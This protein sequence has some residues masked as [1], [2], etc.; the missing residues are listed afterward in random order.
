M[1]SKTT[2]AVLFAAATLL[3][4]TPSAFAQRPT[5]GFDRLFLSFIE[6]AT[7]PESQWWEGQ[8]EFQDGDGFDATIARGI[9]AIEWRDR[10]E[11]GTRIGF[12]D[13]DVD[14]ANVDDGSGA[15]DWEIWGKYYLGSQGG[16]NEFA[17]GAIFT[18][19]TGDDSAGLGTDAFAANIFGAYRRRLENLIITGNIG[20][21]LQDAGRHLLVDS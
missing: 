2:A 21:R 17:V 19:P 9:F 20:L 5:S 11:F 18:I 15:T 3:S 8:I 7:L 4:L 1:R 6:D 14:N 10:V 13:T 12:G 16:V